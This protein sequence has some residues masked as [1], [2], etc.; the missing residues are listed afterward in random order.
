MSKRLA[1]TLCTIVNRMHS[2]GSTD[3]SK[4]ETTST[5]PTGES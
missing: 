1:A 5:V 3:E 2:T 4:G